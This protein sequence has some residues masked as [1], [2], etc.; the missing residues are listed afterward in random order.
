MTAMHPSTAGLSPWE[1]HPDDFP[2][3]AAADQKLLFMLN[4]A[5]LA[6]SC[7]NV[8]PWLFR[9]QGHEVDLVADRR[10]SLP[11]VDPL[12]RELIMSCGA[13]LHHLRVAARYFGCDLQVDPFPDVR[14][15]NVLARVSLGSGCESTVEDIEL[16]N[17]I[18]RRRT[19]RFAYLPDA[20][21]VEILDELQNLALREGAWLNLFSGET[22][23]GTVAALIEQAER[24]QWH[25]K[26]FRDELAA[27]LIPNSSARR[28]GIPGYA[29]GQ[30]SIAAFSEPML[31]R[32]FDLGSTRAAHDR[33]LALQ[34]PILA[35]VGTNDDTPDAWL[36]A[37]QALS[38]VLL[39]ACT[40]DI[41]ASFLNQPIEIA[42]TREALSALT[43]RGGAP[44]VLLRL[45]YGPALKPTPRRAVA[46][47]MIRGK[48]TAIRIS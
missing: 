26:G 12:G 2:A 3:D 10:R 15:R 18:Q 21:P 25:S 5:I 28:D 34:A 13:A 8:Q 1:V 22:E 38:A 20:V 31:V 7:R 6:P 9:L 30:N 23:R 35:A 17:A 39:R 19:N 27:C 14:E 29:R 24:I 40:H 45:G 47:T 37:G 48:H 11:V 33:D 36:Q 41:C 32:T 16:F 46:Q 4:F 44:Q 42:E 43:A